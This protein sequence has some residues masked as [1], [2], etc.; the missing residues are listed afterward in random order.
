MRKVNTKLYVVA[1][2]ITLL[3]FTAGVLL[4]LVIEG[5]RVEYLS[6]ERKIQETN[7][8]SLQLQY[9]YL[10]GLEE[11]KKCPALS[12][13]LNKYIKE[14]DELRVRIENYAQQS[15]IKQEELGLLKRQYVIAQLNYWLMAKRTKKL[16]ETDYV[17]L[18]YFYEKEQSQSMNQ[19][20]VLDY[21]KKKLGDDLLIFAL[22]SE[23]TQEPMI[24]MLMSAHNITSTPS[25]VVEDTVYTGFHSKDD[26]QGILCQSYENKTEVCDE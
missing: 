22:D 24:P 4:G 9:L 23:F 25:I 17:T 8:N 20:V 1:L 3:I 14:T 11:K 12:T 18:L 6:E 13:A 7:F 15:N 21:Y 10:S 26:I 5:E 19:G 2:I 16:C